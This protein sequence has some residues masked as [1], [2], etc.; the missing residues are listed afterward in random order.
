M[1]VA[2]Q[3]LRFYYQSSCSYSICVTNG[4]LQIILF[5]LEEVGSVSRT[6]AW[7]FHNNIRL[8]D[9]PRKCKFWVFYDSYHRLIS[10]MWKTFFV[11]DIANSYNIILLVHMGMLKTMLRW[12]KKC[13]NFDSNRSLKINIVSADDLIV[14]CPVF[15]Y[16]TLKTISPVSAKKLSFSF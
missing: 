11:F 12:G 10:Q 1:S 4:V 2:Y 9:T 14:V 5:V 3:I 16:L 6:K 7:P 8:L 15:E 13:L